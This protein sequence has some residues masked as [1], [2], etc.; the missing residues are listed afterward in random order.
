MKV[1]EIMTAHARSVGPDNT[2]VEA[3]GLMRQLDVGAVPVVEGDDVVG[4]VTDRDMALRAVADGRDPNT[5]MV[6]DVMTQGVIFILSDQ[7][8]EEA[9]RIMQQRQVR[10]LPVLDR[11]KRLVGIVSLGDVA[12]ASNPAF[13]GM[14]LR[15]V[16]ESDRT[17]SHRG[18]KKQGRVAYT[19]GNGARED[20]AAKSGSRSSTK[21]SGRS[22]GAGAQGSTRRN[23]GA[24]SATPRSPQR[25]GGA[26]NR[27]GA[28][29]R[30]GA[31]SASKRSRRGAKSGAGS[32]K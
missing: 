5:A 28:V 12:V 6:R 11:A 15:D 19:L 22:T 9:V 1:H 26:T 21:T 32:R 17:L 25:R 27:G 10:R 14:A 20:S 7:E 29:K 31:S 16:S 23:G 3:A 8:V 2:L 13:G 18:A 4:I 30:R 24:K